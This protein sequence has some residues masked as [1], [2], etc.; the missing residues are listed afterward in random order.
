MRAGSAPRLRLRAERR[1][2]ERSEY[3]GRAG[4]SP[5]VSIYTQSAGSAVYGI[6]PIG[7]K[8]CK[9]AETYFSYM[10]CVDRV[11]TQGRSHC[12]AACA[13][14]RKSA[15]TRS[16]FPPAARYFFHVTPARVA[17]CSVGGKTHSPAARNA[18]RNRLARE[19]RRGLAPDDAASDSRARSTLKEAQP[20]RAG[21][22]E[23]RLRSGSAPNTSIRTHAILKHRG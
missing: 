23:R 1:S 8:Y 3:R 13:P 22:R 10:A 5:S 6:T 16:R 14:I 17:A 19:M 2:A 18:R 7:I 20:A 4:S 21:C 12:D 9:S 15:I 11:R